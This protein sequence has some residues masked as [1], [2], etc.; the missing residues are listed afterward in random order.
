MF[1]K[2]KLNVKACIFLL[3]K[4]DSFDLNLLSSEMI[5]V[6]FDQTKI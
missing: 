4:V 5:F 1:L 2:K 3:Y 6:I